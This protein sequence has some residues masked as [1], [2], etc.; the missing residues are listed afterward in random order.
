[1]LLQQ[2]L[3]SQALIVV[4]ISDTGALEI[5]DSAGSIIWTSATTADSASSSSSSSTSSSSSSSSSSS[6]NTYF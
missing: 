6:Y 5:K 2:Q 3:L 4:S 1:M